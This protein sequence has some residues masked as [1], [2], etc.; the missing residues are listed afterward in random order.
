MQHDRVSAEA[1]ARPQRGD[2]RGPGL[3]ADLG[4]LDAGLRR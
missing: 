3:V 1:V 4:V 2:E